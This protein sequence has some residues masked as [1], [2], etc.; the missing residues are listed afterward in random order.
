M[1]TRNGVLV[2]MLENEKD[3]VKT[4]LGSY[5]RSFGILF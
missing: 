5:T 4:P 2:K 1:I 3:P